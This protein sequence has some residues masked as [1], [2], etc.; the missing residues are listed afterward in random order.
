MANK[1]S[2]Y[3]LMPFPSLYVDNK[4]PEIAELLANRYDANKTSKDLID[5]TLSQLELLPGDQAHLERIKTDVKGTLK[6]HIEKQDWENSS[7][8]VQDAAQ[9][10]ETDA[11]LIASNKSMKNREA[12]INAM[13]EAKLN[14]IPMLDFG[15]DSRSVHESYYYDEE[16]GA[17]I[18]NVYEPMMEQQLDYRTRKEA[19]IG[20]IPASQK[21]DWMGVSRSKTNK[22]AN[23]MVEQYITDTKEG[24]QEFKKLVEMD[25]PQSIPLEER[26]KMAKAQILNDFKEVARQQEFE[27]VTGTGGGDSGRDPISGMKLGVTTT[28]GEDTEINTAFDNMSDKVR[29]IQER[30]MAINKFLASG[31][32]VDGKELSEEENKALQDE[33]NN[34]DMILD[35]NLKKVADQNGIKGERALNKYN[36]IRD[37][38]LEGGNWSED[39]GKRLLAATQYLTYLNTKDTDWAQ[40]GYTA[41]AGGAATGVITAGVNVAPGVGQIGYGMAIT[42]GTIGSGVGELFSQWNSDLRG[43]RDW[44]RRQEPVLGGYVGD[45]EREQLA[46]ELWGDEDLGDMKVDHINGLLGTDFNQNDMEELYKM[47]NAYYTFMIKDE[48]KENGVQVDRMSGDDLFEKVQD[49]TFTLNQRRLAFDMTADGKKL[50]TATNSF[51]Q[52]DIPLNNAGLKFDGM[53]GNQEISKWIEDD[54]GGASKL[55]L[56]GVLLPDVAANIPLRLTFGSTEDATGSVNRSATVSDPNELQAGGWIYD[57]IQKNYGEG[58]KV[59]DELLRRNYDDMGYENVT[60]DRYSSDFAEK[61]K[62]FFGG[63]DEDKLEYKRVI[64]NEVIMNMLVSPEFVY[65]HYKNADGVKGIDGQTGFIPFIITD[66]SGRQSFN[67]AAWQ[68]LQNKPEELQALR[69][70]MLETNLRDFA[71]TAF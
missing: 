27:K 55:T 33:L 8:V 56:E 4:Q 31:K 15:K 23:L 66:S 62:I 25:L 1:Y 63:T 50:R 24:I 19:M 48:M 46:E 3:E 67:A 42:A 10:V 54:V 38:F 9:L 52:S 69:T 58:D 41:L 21:G 6:D 47:T 44:D 64:E 17:Y 53:V 59:Y 5:R 51:I 34:N 30:Q 39:D 11:G 65:E 45:S 43:V 2:R 37:R 32:G 49:Q 68:E 71:G 70:T 35:N 16:T 13:R 22:V 12:E 40:V 28:G 14:G 7:L 36:K 57:L 60:M 26:A 20:N 18:T 29:G 61:E